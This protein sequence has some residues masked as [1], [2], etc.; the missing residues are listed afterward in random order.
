MY[1]NPFERAIEAARK[2]H[3]WRRVGGVVHPVV[4]MECRDVPRDERRNARDERRET[5]QFV[6][7]IVESRNQQRH[8]LE[9]DAPVVQL[10]NGPEDRVNP[11]AQLTIVSIVEALEIDLVE[12]HPRLDVVEDPRG[13]VP[14]RHVSGGESGAARFLENRDGPFARDERLV[15]RADDDASAEVD[16]LIDELAWRDVPRRRDSVG[17]AERLRCHPVLAIGAVEIAAEHSEAEGE[18]T[19]VRVE[20]RLLLHRVALHAPDI[21]PRNL[22]TSVAIEAHLADADGALGNRALMAAGVTTNPALVD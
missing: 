6:G 13:S 2:Q 3:F 14:V 10:A 7:R 11:P 12:I 16:G 20:E 18:R 22:Q 15:V 21:T 8:N 17:I 9:P 5:L 4:L 19:G 1:F